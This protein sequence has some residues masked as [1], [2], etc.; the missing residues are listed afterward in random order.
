MPSLSPLTIN[1][2]F[3]IILRYDTSC[4]SNIFSYEC[5]RYRR[6]L[7]MT[8][9]RVFWL[10]L[11]GMAT[12]CRYMWAISYL[13][14]CGSDKHLAD[15]RW[16]G[17]HSVTWAHG[18]RFFDTRRSSRTVWVYSQRRLSWGRVDWWWYSGVIAI[19]VLKR[20]WPLLWGSI[21]IESQI[22]KKVLIPTYKN[23]G[24]RH[25]DQIHRPSWSQNELTMA[26]STLVRGGSMGRKWSIFFNQTFRHVV[27]SK[28][29]WS[30]HFQE[31]TRN[32]QNWHIMG[33]TV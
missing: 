9:A 20:K 13:D 8:P 21:A 29:W 33:R 26:K 14:W 24:G 10:A 23:I 4:V 1:Y 27:V 16:R 6:R 19:V 28:N 12:L 30:G 22:R 3:D 2:F 31:Q 17:F 11:D 18:A 32:L 15:G 25:P 5:H 7:L